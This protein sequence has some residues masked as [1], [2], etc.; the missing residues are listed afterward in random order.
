[1]SDAKTGDVEEEDEWLRLWLRHADPALDYH[2]EESFSRIRK[3][4]MSAIDLEDQ[5]PQ[6]HQ[7]TP[8]ATRDLES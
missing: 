3:N 1:M 4:I 2:L 6:I 5:V 7:R 8:A